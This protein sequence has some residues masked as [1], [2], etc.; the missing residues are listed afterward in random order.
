MAGQAETLKYFKVHLGNI[1]YCSVDY[2]IHRSA[3]SVVQIDW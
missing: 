2:E 3:V 1:L